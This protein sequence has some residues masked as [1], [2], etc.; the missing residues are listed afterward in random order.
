[1]PVNYSKQ[2]SKSGASIG[3]VV[4]IAKPSTWTDSPNN[5]GLESANW[6]VDTYYPGWLECDGRILLVS[7]Y[8]ALYEVLGNTYGGT[9]DVDFKLPDYRS[10]KLMGT[11]TV[12]GNK[13]IT[14]PSVLPEF[15]PDGN[16]GGDVF[17]PGTVGGLYN[18]ST[19]RQLPPGSETTPGAPSGPRVDYDVADSFLTSLETLT[20]VALIPY[21]SGL[22][23]PAGTG[24]AGGFTDPPILNNGSYLAFG[25]PNTTPFNSLQFTRIAE[26]TF[27]LSTYS[28]ML[29]FVK[30]GND[31]NGG[32]RP[33]N[34]T[35]DCKVRWPDGSESTIV[36]AVGSTPFTIAEW[37][38][39]YDEW[40]EIEV[41]IPVQYRT[42]GVV[43][44]VR[45]DIVAGTEQQGSLEA[46][47]PN[48]GDCFALQRIGFRGG[49]IGG[50]ASDT[51]SLGS[52]RTEGFSAITTDV[53]PNFSGN[54]SFSA[55]N[56]NT[57]TGTRTI[58]SVPPHDHYVRHVQRQNS[59][60]SSGEPYAPG[61]R[62]PFVNN[63]NGS[64]LSFDR[65]GAAV[66]SHSHY[67][68]WGNAVTGLSSYGNDNDSGQGLYNAEGGAA[69]IHDT[70]IQNPGNNVGNQINKTVDIVNQAG[71]N[72]NPAVLQMKDQSRTDFD[73][74]ISVRLE[75]A[76]EIPLMSPYFRV[77]YIIK[78]V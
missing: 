30:A 5:P 4:S 61:P 32:E 57:G 44:Q 37:D 74:A 65:G 14:G 12:D 28:T 46:T 25:T 49:D 23:Q 38:V 70:F 63:S 8:R 68:G 6:D 17:T 75:A 77:K 18:V 1:M 50:E 27:D 47:N 24:E 66:R 35:E 45:Q 10:K 11:G 36:P 62:V 34:H 2:S 64:L 72:L 48:N 73:N 41:E 78:A 15:N 43:V 31:N 40:R 9:V 7:E 55:G 52:F 76:E 13:G 69:T 71:V 53:E 22:D 54:I 26:Y 29:F 59:Q 42:S 19:V 60:A 58:G 33:N 56:A 20:G 16:S 3:T 39:I 21:G 51:F 67:I